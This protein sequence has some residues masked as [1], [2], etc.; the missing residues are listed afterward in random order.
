MS[1]GYE[2]KDG[3]FLFRAISICPVLAE[4][5][6]SSLGGL[7]GCAFEFHD[8]SLVDHQVP[9]QGDDLQAT[10][11]AAWRRRGDALRLAANDVVAGRIVV[12][13][14]CEGR[15]DARALLVDGIV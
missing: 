14:G 11:P 8:E 1:K 9:W 10:K 12:H 5:G 3:S 2:E 15:L 7:W 6:F 4:L 13:E